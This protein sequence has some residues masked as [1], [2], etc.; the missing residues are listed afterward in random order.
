MAAWRANSDNLLK[1]GLEW[2]EEHAKSLGSKVE[3]RRYRGSISRH[4]QE[5]FQK[6]P[7]KG[8]EKEIACEQQRSLERKSRCLETEFSRNLNKDLVDSKERRGSLRQ[9]KPEIFAITLGK[10]HG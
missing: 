10:L 2:E 8:K 3:E 7:K 1:S 5:P 4:S 9:L 6:K